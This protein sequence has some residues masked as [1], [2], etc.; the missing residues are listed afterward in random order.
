MTETELHEGRPVLWCAC[1]KGNEMNVFLTGVF[2]TYRAFDKGRQTSNT[3][4]G[5]KRIH[6]VRTRGGNQKFQDLWICTSYLS[7]WHKGLGS[8]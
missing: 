8:S 6:L 2:S 3:R 7:P 4:I 1:G 5:S